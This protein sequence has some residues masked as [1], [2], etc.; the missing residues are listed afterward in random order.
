MVNVT[1]SM[2]SNG[3]CD[4]KVDECEPLAGGNHDGFGHYDGTARIM[5]LVG[6][7]RTVG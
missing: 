2:V 5:A 1:I 7:R 6:R 4:R 3:R